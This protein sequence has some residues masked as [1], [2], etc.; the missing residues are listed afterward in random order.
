LQDVLCIVNES[1][2]IIKS[3][4]VKLNNYKYSRLEL[5]RL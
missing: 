2:I 5:E 3:F 1:T 4:D